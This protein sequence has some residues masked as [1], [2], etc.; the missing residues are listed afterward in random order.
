MN[1]TFDQLVHKLC[2]LSLNIVNMLI[3]DVIDFDY[4]LHIS[5]TV[6]Q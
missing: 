4:T 5:V 1:I 3:H 6:Y 2:D